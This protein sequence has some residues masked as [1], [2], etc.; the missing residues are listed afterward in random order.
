MSKSVEEKREEKVRKFIVKSK[1]LFKTFIA[2][3]TVDDVDIS[4]LSEKDGGY[5]VAGSVSATSPTG[6]L[7]VYSYTASVVV[8]GDGECSFSKLN[9]TAPEA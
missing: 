6:K 3:D 7:K 5:E 9:V 1:K 8:D 4:E 2:K